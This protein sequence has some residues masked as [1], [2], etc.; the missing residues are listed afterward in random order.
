MKRSHLI[1]LGAIGLFAVPVAA[2]S[3]NVEF[4]TA[5]TAPSASYAGVGVPGVWNS[6]DGMANFERLALVGLDGAPIAADIMN[7]GFDVIEASDIA[8]TSGDDEALLDDCF[9]SFNDPIDGCLFMRFLE[10]GAYRVIMYG[11][12]PD[13]VSLLS[14]LRI[15]QNTEDPVLVGGAWAGVHDEGITYMAQIATV[16]LDGRLD[17]HSGLPSGNIRSVCNGIQVIQLPPPC[18][19]DLTGDG[20]LNFFDVSAF[21]NA[22]TAMDPLADFTGDGVFDFFDVSAFLNAFN[23]GCP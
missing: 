19:A 18:P 12:A 21:L 10:P 20:V 6:F 9:T 5:G 23:A 7:I 8:T 2:Q 1:T 15:D 16:G 3:F 22:Y 4:G 17:I 13:D 14:R 11:I